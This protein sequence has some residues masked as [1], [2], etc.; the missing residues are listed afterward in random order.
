LVSDEIRVHSSRAAVV[1]SPARGGAIEEYTLFSSLTNYANV[2]TRRHEA[3]HDERPQAHQHGGAPPQ[4]AIPSD[5]DDRALFV[6]R[7]LPAELTHDAYAAGR[8]T[9]LKSW[10]RTSLR[11]HIEAHPE[12]VEVVLEGEGLE[13]RIR[14]AADGALTVSYRWD[15]AGLPA[16]AR[17]APEISLA[18]ALDLVVEPA[19]EVWRFPIETVAKSERGLERTAQGESLTPLWPV[20]AGGARVDLRLPPGAASQ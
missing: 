11:Q 15:A 18:G 12:A 17:F 9:P 19:V 20:S 7:V 8:Y 2:L 14:V 13:K 16:D 1:I 5:A 3:Y 4:E 6:D 10:A